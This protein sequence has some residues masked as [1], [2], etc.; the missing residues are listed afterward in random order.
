[1]FFPYRAAVFLDK[2]K[3]FKLFSPSNHQPITSPN[4]CRILNSVFEL[5]F[6]FLRQDY[7]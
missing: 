1:M 3:K 2:Y 6:V 4:F 7:R 5:L